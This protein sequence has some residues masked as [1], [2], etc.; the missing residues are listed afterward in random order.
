MEPNT[1]LWAN[2]SV[3]HAA[4]GLPS[5]R[6]PRR[7]K[8]PRSPHASRPACRSGCPHLPARPPARPHAGGVPRAAESAPR[9]PCLSNQAPR[10]AARAETEAAL[11][12]RRVM[13][14]LTARRASALPA[15]AGGPGFGGTRGTVRPGSGTS[16]TLRRVVK[17]DGPSAALPRALPSQPGLGLCIPRMGAMIPDPGGFERTAPGQK[18]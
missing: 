1:E 14:S 17:G 4:R 5:S 12:W 15:P 13:T 10:A 18:Q 7:A 8:R 6:L 2:K 9:A 3:P 11:L 16:V